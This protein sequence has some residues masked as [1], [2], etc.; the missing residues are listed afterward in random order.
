[1]G[2]SISIDF[3]SSDNK[4]IATAIYTG[5][6][7]T[8]SNY[9]FV[10]DLTVFSPWHDCSNSDM[11][12]TFNY[13][14][15]NLLYT[16]GTLSTYLNDA[17]PICPNYVNISSYSIPLYSYTSKC[18][19][20]SNSFSGNYLGTLVNLDYEIDTNIISNVNCNTTN[21]T[22]ISSGQKNTTYNFYYNSTVIL[23]IQLL[24]TYTSG[25]WSV[26]GIT[27]TNNTA[28]KAQTIVAISFLTNMYYNLSYYTYLN[29]LSSSAFNAQLMV[30]YGLTPI[31]QIFNTLL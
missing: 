18:N 1:M 23:T 30:I 29:I 12:S 16:I 11:Y 14:Y 9:Y 19:S 26:N 6:Q 2:Y 21:P 10:P 3:A 5:T 25:N 7:N 31:I 22:N 15:L 13:N 8:T 24:S 27:I 28:T 17:T 4:Y 20:S